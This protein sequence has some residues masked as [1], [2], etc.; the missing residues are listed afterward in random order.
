MKG[1]KVQREGGDRVIITRE[2]VTTTTEKISVRLDDSRALVILDKEKE[3]EA[4]AAI[5]EA[6]EKALNLNSKQE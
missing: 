4:I 5:I 1:G 3:T 2:L 6:A